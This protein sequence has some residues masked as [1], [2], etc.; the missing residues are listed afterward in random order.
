MFYVCISTFVGGRRF[1]LGVFC[2]PFFSL[3]KNAD[4]TTTSEVE[5]NRTAG[6]RETFFFYIWKTSRRQ[7]VDTTSFLF[8]LHHVNHVD[9]HRW[10]LCPLHGRSTHRIVE[11][12]MGGAKTT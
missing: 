3:T 6:R 2:G 7:S 1:F 5:Y 12:S 11:S 9:L 4:E 8:F 10:S